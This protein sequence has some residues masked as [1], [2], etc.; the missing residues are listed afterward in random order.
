MHQFHLV[1]SLP[2]KFTI[3]VMHT[4]MIASGTHS[5]E[6]EITVR[7]INQVSAAHMQI[8][9]ITKESFLSNVF[10]L[11]IKQMLKSCI[12]EINVERAGKIR[13]NQQTSNKAKE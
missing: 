4:F 10:I 12:K 2:R 11:E 7:L 6:H 5:E 8:C 3:P 9:I 1:S 13:W